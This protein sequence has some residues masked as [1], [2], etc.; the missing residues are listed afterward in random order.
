MPL[1]TPLLSPST[2]LRRCSRISGSSTTNEIA[3][4]TLSTYPA[5]KPAL[6]PYPPGLSTG[7]MVNPM[8]SQAI[9][10][11][12]LCLYQRPPQLHHQRNCDGRH[13]HLLR[14]QYC[15]RSDQPHRPNLLDFRGL[16]H[17][18]NRDLHLESLWDL[19]PAPT[20]CL[21]GPSTGETAIRR[22]SPAILP[23]PLTRTPA[24][25]T[26]T[27]SAQPPPTTLAPIPPAHAPSRVDHLPPTLAISG[28]S[29]VNEASVYTLNLA[30]LEPGPHTISSWAINWGDGHTQTVTGNPSSRHSHFC[31]RP[32]QLHNFCDCH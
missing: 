21:P 22:R 29:A 13:L 30:G 9:H 28:A 15:R 4:Y 7:V 31:R 14:L 17:Q 19:K 24:A 1:P 26:I 23:A 16:D 18:R 20:S 11:R 3:T 5:R 32:Q 25:R 6:T 2:T 8:S 10:P 12:R 27:R